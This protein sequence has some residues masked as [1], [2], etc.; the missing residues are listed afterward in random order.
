MYSLATSDQII[1]HFATP[2]WVVRDR[3][4]Q[5]RSNRY[6]QLDIQVR[7]G[8]Y[9]ATL[10]N[11]LDIIAENLEDTDEPLR[12]L[13]DQQIRDLLYLQAKYKIEKK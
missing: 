10:A 4:E 8:D 11:T 7:S 1:T 3:A 6:D 2:T 13:L 12:H 5:S 9:F